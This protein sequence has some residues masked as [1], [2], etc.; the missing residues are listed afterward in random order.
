MLRLLSNFSIDASTSNGGQLRDALFE[1]RP[2]LGTM[3]PGGRRAGWWVLPAVDFASASLALAVVAPVSGAPPFPAIPLA[4][5]L[6]VA[7]YAALRGYA[8]DRPAAAPGG[9]VASPV[10]QLLAAT[11]FAW[12]A[13]QLIPLSIGWGLA[14][15]VAFAVI[16]MAARNS[17]RQLLWRLYHPER[18]LLVGEDS[19]AELLRRSRGLRDHAIL[20]GTVP[21]HPNGSASA[22]RIE[23]LE[24]VDLYGA[25]RVVIAGRHADDSDLLDLVRA[26]K[27]IGVP[28]SLFPRPLDLLEAP[29]A[30]PSEVGGV[31]MF[32]VEALAS[33]PALPYRGPDRRRDRQTRVTVVVPAMNEAENIGHVLRRLPEGLHEVVLVDGSSKD[34]TVEVARQACPGIR[35]L[36]QSGRGKGD[37]LRLGFAAATGN[38]IVMLD[39]DG[40]ADPDEIPRFVDALEAG[41]DF[42]KGSRFL[43]GGG[44][45]DITRL[46]SLG[47]TFLSG[48]A[49]LLNGTHF[50]DLC[51]GYNAF[52]ARCLPFISL[53]VPGFE[54]ETLINLRIADAGMTITEVPSYE[55]NRISGES[56]LKT[57]RDGFRVLATILNESRR[58]NMIADRGDRANGRRQPHKPQA[59]Q[60]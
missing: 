18:W 20:V 22:H 49:N 32:E 13:S 40:S 17:A 56:H 35:V 15:L 26:F 10:V 60:A 51:Y 30:L 53:D 28:V 38:L 11:P 50:T 25:D 57:F 19:T 7:I 39:A 8:S 5:I 58:H 43:E 14:L 34:G 45:D 48:T 6:P 33:H 12:L 23:A 52:W 36:T 1:D 41:A 27:S 9:G 47:N 44:S 16:G 31:P 59:T 24:A 37:A 54:V 2:T 55:E 4:A 42:A 21:P 3:P 29:A 46:R